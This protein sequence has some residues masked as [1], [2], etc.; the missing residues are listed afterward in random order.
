MYCCFSNRDY[1]FVKI[2]LL[3]RLTS[4]DGDFFSLSIKW[5]EICKYLN[6]NEENLRQ[7]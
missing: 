1:D 5:S 3:S 4:K 2:F 7:K 6:E